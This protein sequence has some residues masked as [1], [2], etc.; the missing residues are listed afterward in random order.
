MDAGEICP[1]AFPQMSCKL[2]ITSVI[3]DTAGVIMARKWLDF[4]KAGRGVAS[5]SDGQAK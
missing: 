3:N 5:R 1:I 4:R 2:D